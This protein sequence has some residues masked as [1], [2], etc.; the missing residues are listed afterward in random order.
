MNTTTVATVA[1]SDAATRRRARLLAVVGA[2]GAALIF[3]AV[4]E[5]A[6][7]LDLRGAAFGANAETSDV[8]PA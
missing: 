8:G 4:V 7:G 6:F 5:L 1:T 3:W 2:V